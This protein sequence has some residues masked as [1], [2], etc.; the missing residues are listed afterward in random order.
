M[1]K[2]KSLLTLVFIMGFSIHSFA[3]WNNDI[4]A[5]HSYLHGRSYYALRSGRIK[6]MVQAD[7]VGN[8][9][10]FS[11]ILFD[12]Q[13]ASQSLL[14][15]K[16][17]NYSDENRYFSS[18]LRVRM[19]SYPFTAF[20]Q[21]C[22]T[23][24]TLVDGIPSAEANWWA[25]GF[26]VREV[27]TPIG[28]N[29]TFR[30]SITLK[31]SDL[32]DTDQAFIQLFVP[33]KS[34]DSGSNYLT[35]Q[36]ENATMAVTTATK[37]PV[38]MVGDD[39]LEV[40]PITV[41]PGDYVTLTSYI[42][43]DISD[44]KAG[45]NESSIKTISDRLNTV[46]DMD[47]QFTDKMAAKWSHSNRLHTKDKV[48][49]ELYDVARYTLPGFI[50][51]N[52]VMD[53]GVFEYGGQWVRDASNTCMG[54]IHNGEFE[55]SRAMI[56]YMLK[57]MIKDEGVTMI[58]GG[59][60]APDLEQFDQMGELM[61]VMRSYLDWTGD[62]SLLQEYRSKILKMVERPLNSVF[63]DETGMVHNRREFWERTFDDAYELAYQTWVVIGLRCAAEMSPYLGAEDRADTWAREADVIYDAMI[64]HPTAKLVDNGHLTKRRSRADKNVVHNITYPSYGPGAPSGLEAKISIYPDATMALPIA[65]NLID[66]KS[67]LAKNTI[68]ETEKLWNK[69]WNTGGHDRYNTSSQCDTPGPWPFAT[70]F[71]LRGEHEAGMLDYSRRSLEWLH[72]TDGANTGAW[73]E[74][75]TTLSY[76]SFNSGLVIWTTAEVSYFMIHHLLGIKFDK[77]VMT[78]KPNLYST[79]APIKANLRYQKSRIDVEITGNGSVK[80]AIINGKKH[81]PDNQ[82]RIVMPKG[83]SGG[84]IQIVN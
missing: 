56:E 25:G 26:S 8:S 44:N 15:E 62:A 13:N 79:T 73:Y 22:T 2:I 60:D 34:C 46:A 65:M 72:G 3:Q 70:A 48:V 1:I 39:M 17:Y 24:W 19:K 4:Y 81:T 11:Y 42:L 49:Q 66:P 23:K 29:G 57:S 37:Y 32:E 16:A 27:I 51:D 28:D 71:I 33:G 74:E 77:G 75:T 64:N 14:K 52:G 84:N 58:A 21:T 55:Q 35:Y 82:G 63:R 78:I 80:Y 53:A 18:A 54:M 12:G 41:D 7:K 59:F 69:R 76:N 61:Y 30:R 45:E 38:S 10:A 50:A 83:F 20:G 9:P 47:K 68:L 36:K 40:G 43:L 31:S 67:D 6:M 5:N